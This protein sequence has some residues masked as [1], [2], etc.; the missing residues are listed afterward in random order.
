[1]QDHVMQDHE[2]LVD[3][4]SGEVLEVVS[5]EASA[6]VEPP[7]TVAPSAAPTPLPAP[8]PPL[9]SV[10]TRAFAHWA[11]VRKTPAWLASATLARHRWADTLELTAAEFNA[12]LDATRKI[13]LG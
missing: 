12:A 9:P 8:P 3:G 2:D 13:R 7:A 10:P 6:T 5:M 11:R 1:M 4:E